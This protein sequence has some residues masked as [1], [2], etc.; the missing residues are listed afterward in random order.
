L[1]NRHGSTENS[2]G[3]GLQERTASALVFT[4]QAQ[5]FLLEI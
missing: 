1:S 5:R 3:H 4:I 2:R